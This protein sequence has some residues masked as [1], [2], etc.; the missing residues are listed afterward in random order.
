MLDLPLTEVAIMLRQFK[1]EQEVYATLSCVPMAARRKLDRVGLKISL[2]QWQQLGRGERLAICHLPAE[3]PEEREALDLLVREAVNNRCGTAVKELPAD[4]RE[5]AE[6]PAS[7]AAE[8]VERA[9]TAGVTFGQREWDRLDA[10][11]RYALTKLG[12]GAEA[13][14]NFAAALKELV[15][16]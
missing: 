16:R 8:L 10:D 1:F 14:H 15:E 5:S 12:G 3:L 11:E 13:S 9:R 7:P 4:A 6:P 2:S